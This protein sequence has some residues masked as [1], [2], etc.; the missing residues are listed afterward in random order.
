MTALPA[1][2]DTYSDWV[3]LRTLILIR[4]IAIFGQVA[5]IAVADRVYGVDIALGPAFM[6]VG[7]AVIANLV[8]IFVF[9]ENQRLTEFG[10]TATLL[11]DT[12]QIAALLYLTGGL[13]NPFALL[14]VAPATIAATVLRG[15]VTV[16]I[17]A[18]TILLVT[19]V[20]FVHQP[21]ALRSGGEIRVPVVFEVGVWVAIVLGV[22]LAN[23][24]RVNVTYIYEFK[25]T[26]VPILV[27]ILFVLLAANVVAIIFLEGFA[28]VLPDDPTGYTLLDQIRGR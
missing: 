2:R 24:V 5:A 22:V 15:R 16:L 13:H 17:G 3:R 18:V 28:W 12:A 27:G 19:V 20:A 9:P 1:A 8:A 25:E 10:A 7:A 11:F 4:W 23:Q 26:L 14:I 21:L 6:V